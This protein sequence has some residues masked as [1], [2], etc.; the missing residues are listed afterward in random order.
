[1]APRIFHRAL[2]FSLWQRS[3][4]L[5]M[6]SQRLSLLLTR[7]MTILPSVRSLLVMRSL[8]QIGYFGERSKVCALCIEKEQDLRLMQPILSASV[9]IIGLLKNN[10]HV[11]LARWFSY[12]ESLESTQTALASLA[13]SVPRV[14]VLIR[15]ENNS[16][17]KNKW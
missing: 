16:L 12:L 10:K 8:P 11:H 13:G 5:S 14:C 7:S 3:C 6:H 2:P 9:K 4:L 15:Y 17:G 1:M